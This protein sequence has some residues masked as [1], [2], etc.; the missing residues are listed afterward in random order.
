MLILVFDWRPVLCYKYFKYDFFF[1][2]A[3]W[4]LFTCFLTELNILREGGN[5]LPVV[6]FK[7]QVFSSK[8][9]YSLVVT[10]DLFVSQLY[11]WL[12]TLLIWIRN[13]LHCMQLQQSVDQEP[14]KSIIWKKRG[15][16]GQK[17]NLSMPA[18]NRFLIEKVGT[19]RTEV[20]IICFGFLIT[21]IMEK[22]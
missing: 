2:G 11:I 17:C 7:K 14:R 22:Q 13:R 8:C 18:E 3:I 21:T 4:C 15:R 19:L 1:E 16:G 20:W 12:I 9:L 10:L 5:K 6:S